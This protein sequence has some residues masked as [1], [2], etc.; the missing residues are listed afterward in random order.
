MTEIK[1]EDKKKRFFHLLPDPSEVKKEKTYNLAF[2]EHKK[3]VLNTY[4]TLKIKKI[5]LFLKI[6]R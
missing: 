5:T 6:K 1:K 2:I 4:L 3:R